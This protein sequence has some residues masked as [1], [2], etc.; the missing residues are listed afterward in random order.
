MA[1]ATSTR[2]GSSWGGGGFG[3]GGGSCPRAYSWTGTE[4][5]L[6]SGTFGGSLFASAQHTDHDVLDHLSADRSRLRIRLKNELPETEHI[7]AITL[8]VVD[9]P[10]G[11]KVVPTDSGKL[12]TFRDSKSPTAAV[13]SRGLDTLSMVATRDG[14]EW[15]SNLSGRDPTRTADARDGLMLSFAKPPGAK[16]G[17]LWINARNTNWASSMLTYLLSQLGP[18]LPDWWA[19]MNRDDKARDAFTSFI[20]RDGALLVEVKTTTGWASRGKLS[21]AGP[22]VLKDQALELPIDDLSGDV[23]T[24]RLDAPVAF[25]S[26]DSVAVSFEDDAPLEIHDLSPMSAI[27]KDGVDV[28][29]ELRAIDGS[30]YSTVNGDWAELT[31]DAPASPKPGFLRSFVVVSTG[32][33]VPDITPDPHADPA[34]FLRMTSDPDA[35][36]RRALAM[37]NA[38]L[39]LRLLHD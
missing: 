18:A 26:I 32:H 2:G 35:A 14:R 34:L 8:R 25:W 16:R 9:H 36:A 31:F 13:D 7:D 15:T 39:V 30:A 11:T 38:S 5:I 4:W 10:V 28:R 17:K 33:Y 19:T 12:L 3:G 37:L 21:L 24:V 1:L 20:E 29:E 22:E 27:T 6:D 23:L